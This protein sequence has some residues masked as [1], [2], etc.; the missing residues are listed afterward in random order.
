MF[1]TTI[2]LFLK[3]PFGKQLSL[4]ESIE[5]KG[6]DDR[7][8]LLQTEGEAVTDLRPGGRALFDGR[9]V[10]VTAETGYVSAGSRIRVI[11]VQGNQITVKEIQPS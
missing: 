5:E 2:A 1:F 11:K 9:R 3:S 8:A 6:T 10:D 4:D 7:S